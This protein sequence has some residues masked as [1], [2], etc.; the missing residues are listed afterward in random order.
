MKKGIL[1]FF[2]LLLPVLIFI[3]LRSFGKNEFEVPVLFADS[4][5]VPIMCKAYTYNKPYTVADSTLGTIGWKASD[6]L[7]LIVFTDTI[8]ER[9]HERA[10]QLSRVKAEFK[11][12][13]YKIVYVSPIETNSAIAQNS[14]AV[15]PTVMTE[16]RTCI[17]LMKPS[18]DIAIV[19]A[20]KRIRGQYNLQDREDA[21][22]MIMLEMN[23]LFKRY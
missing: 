14:Y 23:I 17:F 15:S 6:S 3:F 7:T 12:E 19:D 21:D 10:I 5:S 16:L 13:S 1:L 2:A 9:N 18:D 22:R 4:V 11:N 20:R 8:A